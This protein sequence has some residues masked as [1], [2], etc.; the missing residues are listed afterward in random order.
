[1]KLAKIKIRNYRCFGPE[2]Q[3]IVVDDLTAFIGNNST[4]KTAALAAINTMFSE[5][6]NERILQRSDFHV[7]SNKLPED[8]ESQELYIETVFVFDQNTS[9]QQGEESAIPI[10]FQHLIVAEPDGNPY[11]R[12]RLIAKWEKSNTVEGSIDSQ[13]YY[14]TCPESLPIS[15]DNYTRASRRDLD[16]IRVIYIPA[17][18]D[19]SKQLK[20]TSGTMMYQIMNSINWSDATKQSIKT[21]IKEL[22]EVYEGETGV[23]MFGESIGKQWK[24]YD[25]EKRYSNAALRFNSTSI[26]TS[27]K[28]AEV[29]FLPTETG[30]EYTI[31]QMSDG[32]RSLFY[33][34]LV[35]SILDVE[36]KIKLEYEADPEHT[37]Y[38]RIP[39]L[40][41]LVALEEPENHIAPHLLGRLINN[42]ESIATKDNAQAIMTS[43][44]P[45]IIKRIDPETLRYFRLS[46]TN[47][48]LVRSITLP[49]EEDV[50]DQYKY[51]KEAVRAY[52]ELYFSKLVILGEG[53][54]EEVLLPRFWEIVAEKTDL[55]CISIVPL[56][57]RHV[58]HFW[59]LLNDLG[60]PYVTLLDLDREREEGGWARIKYVLN[61]L[62]KLGVPRD[63]LL[64]T[65]N[66]VLSKEQFEG[67][68][69]WDATNKEVMASWITMLES[70]DVFFSSPLDIDF[71]MLEQYLDDYKKTL[72]KNEGPRLKVTKDGKKATIRISEIETT[73]S[74]YEGEYKER[75]KNDIRLTLKECGGEGSTY[76]AAQQQLMIWYSYFFLN[77]GKPSTHF[78]MLS[79]IDSE[80]LKEKMPNVFRKLINTAMKKIHGDAL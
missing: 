67:M 10:F 73:P 69:D 37:S 17:V 12:I 54:S 16:K 46:D 63:E 21:K 15:E 45:A 7:P 19:P 47:T 49:K 42:L 1:M 80:K 79:S 61:Q 50:D 38:N 24:A 55:S 59:R 8:I 72:G 41:T 6:S 40:F 76:S 44:S 65:D 68:A 66:G 56:G 62:I 22:N 26:E 31:D 13:I 36:N 20:N 4:G 74:E 34:S 71:L 35:D 5:N 53:D 51:I 48:T 75:I 25:N 57:G 14:I 39:A 2:E 64:K 23:S 32:L 30:K 77:R 9:E 18:R 70:R 78:L 58:N 43:H 11:L 60:I 28:K 33:I 52:P 27:I 3:T 29:V